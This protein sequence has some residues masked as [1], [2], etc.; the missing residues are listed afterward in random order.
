MIISGNSQVNAQ[1]ATDS[2]EHNEALNGAIG[3]AANRSGQV[4]ITEHAKVNAKVFGRRDG[5]VIGSAGYIDTYVSDPFQ[6]T[7]SGSP[8]V[9]ASVQPVSLPAAKKLGYGFG[10]AIGSGYQSKVPAQITLS[11]SPNLDLSLIHI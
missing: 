10:A 4:T 1:T 11:G 8:T 3:S 7:I 5:A 9:Q 2:A 6:V